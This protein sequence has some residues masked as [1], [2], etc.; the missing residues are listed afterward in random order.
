ME[1]TLL[2]TAQAATT[3]GIHEKTV[4]R[5]C[6]EGKLK[7][8]QLHLRSRKMG[9]RIPKAALV[10]LRGREYFGEQAQ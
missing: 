7:G 5:W 4:T 6:R 1:S 9:W 10:E 2:T 8:A 3:L